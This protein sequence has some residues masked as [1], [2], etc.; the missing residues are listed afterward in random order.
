MKNRIVQN[1]IFPEDYNKEDFL[2]FTLDGTEIRTKAE[3]FESIEKSMKFPGTCKCMF[4]RLEDWMR[5]LSWFPKDRGICI[6]I[7]GSESFLSGDPAF[8]KDLK[9]SFEET[10]LP[11]WEDEVLATVKGGVT[12][13]FYVV[14][15][16]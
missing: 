4:S 5:D 6:V 3:F 9:E 8:R 14:M 7:T 11:F 13:R 2:T 16:Q 12:R 1:G 15:K 10:I